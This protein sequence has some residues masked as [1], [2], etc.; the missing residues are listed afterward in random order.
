MP[1]LIT[2]VDNSSIVFGA[3]VYNLSH[4]ELQENFDKMLKLIDKNGHLCFILDLS[5]WDMTHQSLYNLAGALAQRVPGSPHDSRIVTL[6]V[7]TPDV[8]QILEDTLA[9]HGEKLEM[10]RFD[11]LESA[12]NFAN[13][14]I[15]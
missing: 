1:I 6:V 8:F 3:Y 13:G 9:Q 5:A 15:H 2:P 11:N 14:F 12:Y 10:I 7:C 4:N